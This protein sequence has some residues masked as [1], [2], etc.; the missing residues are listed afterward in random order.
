MSPEQ[1]SE[2]LAAWVRSR[3]SARDVFAEWRDT[4]VGD[5]LVEEAM[6]RRRIVCVEDE[7]PRRTWTL[8]E[9]SRQV[10]L[11]RMRMEP[12]WEYGPTP[13]AAWAWEASR[14][15]REALGM[16]EPPQSRQTD[17]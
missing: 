10:G 9:G 8:H 5:P 7:G 15:T 4:T 14:R 3:D 17:P 16:D 13:S 11:V 12:R 6:P 1:M 2:R